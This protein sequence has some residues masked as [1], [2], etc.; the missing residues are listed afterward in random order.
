VLFFV[1]FLAACSSSKQ[2]VIGAPPLDGTG[3]SDGGGTAAKDTNNGSVPGTPPEVS[4]DA[5]TPTKACNPQVDKMELRVG[6]PCTENGQCE[7]C[8]CYDEAYLAPFRF[9]TK[10]CSSGV[11]SSCSDESLDSEEF[12]CLKF[13]GAQIKDHDLKVQSLCMP[14][15]QSVDD[16]K[17]YGPDDYNYCP[18][19]GTQWEGKTV[20]A[21]NTCQTSAP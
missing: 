12:K 2:T 8:Y 16:C 7:T 13:T 9:C 17:I 19:N 3:T 21:R 14:T 10:D 18:N 1:A 5:P 11:N 20:Q 15:C 4:E 6:M